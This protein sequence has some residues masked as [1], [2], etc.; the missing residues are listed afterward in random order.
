MRF[1]R[2]GAYGR[3]FLLLLGLAPALVT[4]QNIASSCP[5]SHY[6]ESAV[7]RSVHDGD[8][9]KLEDGRK[10]RLIGI[11][12]PELA[13]SGKPEQAF[14]SEAR[15]QLKRLVAS[16]NNRVK[17]VYGK[18]RL[19]RYK[20]T[21]AHLFLPNN[22]NLQVALLK[23][24]LATAS[25]YPP[26]VAFSECY[27]QIEQIAQCKSLGIW[28]DDDYATLNSVELEANMEGFRIISGQVERVSESDKGVWLFLEGGLMIG[29]RTADLP[30]F[31]KDEL[32]S[33]SHQTITVRGWLH[34][35][36]KANKG[37]K[38]YMRLRHPS[39]ITPV[40]TAGNVTKC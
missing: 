38:F 19:D 10:I 9:V 33:L 5:A 31:D 17:L 28:S 6:D 1:H 39:A 40:T 24:G 26:N 20:R 14:A 11:N 15:A 35:K 22:Q 30:N 29:I 4:A 2:K 8:T 25:V 34:P 27:Q 36:K 37:V 18:E 13:R 3:L 7:I 32:K 12:T 21:L 23:R 16:S